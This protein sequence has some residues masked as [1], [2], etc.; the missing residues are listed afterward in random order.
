MIIRS[1]KFSTKLVLILSIL[2]I[3]GCASLFAWIL[4]GPRSLSSIT[5]SIERELSSLSKNINVTIEESFIKWDKEEKAIVIE[6]SGISVLNRKSNIPV[7]RFPK[8]AFDFSLLN[9]LRGNLVSSDITLINPSFYLDTTKKSLYFD[10]KEKDDVEA[11]SAFNDVV[12]SLKKGEYSFPVNSIR[13][14]NADLFISNGFSDFVWHAKDG[15]IRID[16]KSKVIS[17]LNLNFGKEMTYLG[18]EISYKEGVYDN[19]LKFKDLPSYI[20]SDLFPDNDIL[21]NVNLIS[22]GNVNFLISEEGEMI[23]TEF[24][25]GSV[26]GEVELLKAFAEKFKILG[27][28]AKGSFYDGFSMLTLDKFDAKID[29]SIVLISGKFANLLPSPD[30]APL[31]KADVTVKDFKVNNLHKYWP[32]LLGEEVR[33]WVVDNITGA[34][35]AKATGSFNFTPEYFNRMYEWNRSGKVGPIPR[36]AE[37]AIDALIEVENGKVTYMEPYPH[38][39]DIS[40]TVSFTGKEMKVNVKS[41][42]IRDSLVN[43]AVVI[44]EDMYEKNSPVK[45]TGEFNAYVRDSIAFLKPALKKHRLTKHLD[46]IYHATGTL[47]GNV[48]ISFPIT[49]SLSY[50][51]FDIEIN[52]KFSD[53]KLPAFINGHDVTDSSFDLTLKDNLLNVDG[54][55]GILKGVA[56]VSYNRDITV[57]NQADYTIS[58]KFTPEKLKKLDIADIPEF[59]K[60]ELFLEV[61]MRER[62]GTTYANG[63]ADLAESEISIP[64]ADFFKEV[65]KKSKL[66][67][68]L[69]N[70]KEGSINETEVKNFVLSGDDFAINGSLKINNAKLN[71]LEIKSASYKNNDYSLSYKLENNA[72]VVQLNGKTLDLSSVSF[73]EYFKDDKTDEN[74][75]FSF[76]AAV[77]KVFMKNSESLSKLTLDMDCS[78]ELCSSINAYAKAARD[79]FVVLSVKPVGK[80]YSFM[81]E[82]DNAG[83][84]INAFGVSKHIEGGRLTV[85]STFSKSKNGLVANGL[86]QI[87][88]FTAIKTPILGKL[89]TLASLKGI[90]DLLN[91]NGIRFERFA[92]PFHISRGVITL[93]D[94]KT[95]GSSIG[96]TSEG[97]IDMNSGHIDLSGAIVPAYE[98]NKVLG[99]I[100]L[101]GNLLVGKKNEGV[102]ATKYRV[103]GPYEDVKI[104]VN[105]L[106][107]LTPG[108][109]R[110]IFDIF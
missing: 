14:K 108:F 88:D 83:S 110:N 26:T 56:K 35:V 86:V 24:D 96:I 55:F 64:K 37:N 66:V 7:A 39:D 12:E 3:L 47:S 76:K 80:S 73:G 11:N 22:S 25:I 33:G 84:V 20:L 92:A 59:I 51:R 91:N 109:L 32:I 104:T 89:L 36:M 21:K 15:Y 71:S 72:H 94:A 13:L 87:H 38:I 16:K 9:L 1:L 30:F 98:V 106:T 57:N 107:I 69:N 44:I 34:E 48:G 65:N 4:T 46:S 10:S 40:G 79:S 42:K 85:E 63:T 77:D 81:L 61:K 93:H 19:Q 105:P 78:S 99:D 62:D 29:D 27:A 67:F 70:Y 18:A 23:Q 82:T 74:N 101:L 28:K 52:S 49:N 54:T 103:K 68:A 43:N 17:E 2:F 95:A 45:I 53:V 50:D 41:A 58:G 60:N 97:T 6:A 75:A 102:I 100:P 90:S 5:P 8:I 31:I